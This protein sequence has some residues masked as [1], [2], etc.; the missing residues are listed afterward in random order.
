MPDKYYRPALLLII[1]FRMM[2]CNNHCE[3]QTTGYFLYHIFLITDTN[4]TIPAL[5]QFGNEFNMQYTL[6]STDT[7]GNPLTIYTPR[8]IKK[9]YYIVNTDTTWYISKESPI[10]GIGVFMK[11]LIRGRI[12]LYQL[13]VPDKQKSPMN[14]KVEYFLWKNGWQLP[15][16]TYDDEVGSLLAHF[17][18]CFQ[19]QYKIKSHEYGIAQFRKILAEYENCELINKYD[20]TGE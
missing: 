13:I 20:F 14:Y 8:D 1:L 5:V 3:A 17:S 18:N 11:L 6:T 12:D 16:I 7:S 10:D 9:F 4:D 19:L 2:S 15:A